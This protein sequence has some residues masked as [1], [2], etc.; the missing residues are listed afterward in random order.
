MAVLHFTI[1]NRAVYEHF[2]QN[3]NQPIIFGLTEN[4]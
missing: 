3:E 4:D 1:N 2:R